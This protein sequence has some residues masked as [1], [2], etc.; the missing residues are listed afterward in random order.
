M[1]LLSTDL[2]NNPFLQHYEH[3]LTCMGL[4]HSV[5]N[6]TATAIQLQL[7][8]K[9]TKTVASSFINNRIAL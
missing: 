7:Q 5:T 4:V 3:Y 6:V 1:L 9:L 2:V 8:K